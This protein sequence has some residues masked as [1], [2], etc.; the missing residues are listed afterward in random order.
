MK[1]IP[2]HFARFQGLV[3]QKNVKI[4]DGK[5]AAIPQ[6]RWLEYCVKISNLW[7]GGLVSGDFQKT[8]LILH[9]FLTYRATLPL[10]YLPRKCVNHMKT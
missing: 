3:A 1:K 6:P 5:E 8:P 7:G 9:R 10:S 2:F 4:K